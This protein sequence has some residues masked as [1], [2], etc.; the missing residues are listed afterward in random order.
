MGY[1]RE[2]EQQE[3]VIYIGEITV[4]KREDEQMRFAWFVLKVKCKLVSLLF[5]PQKTNEKQ[6][7]MTKRYFRKY[8][9]VVGENCCIYSDIITPESYLIIIGDNVTISNDVQFITHDNSIDRVLKDKSDIFGEI[10]IGNNCFI[11]AHTLILPGVTLADNVI[12]GSGSVV[13][14]SFCEK[15]IIIAG[16][17]ARKIGDWTGFVYK[18]GDMSFDASG[19]VRKKIMEH[20]EMVLRDR[21]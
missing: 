3:R 9:V 21:Q 10:K 5:P 20:P 7:N 13:T 18:Y 19:D 4:Y 11:G 1:R 2:K 8:G 16:N 14:K 15:R 12:I 6:K 17:P